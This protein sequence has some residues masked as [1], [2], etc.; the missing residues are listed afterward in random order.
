MALRPLVFLVRHGETDSNRE[1]RFAG[2]SADSLNSRGWEQAEAVARWAA[3]REEKPVRV[4]TSP[5]RRA[6]QTARVLSD[7]LGAPVRRVRELHE[8][9]VGAWKGRTAAEVA[10]RWPEAYRVWK[11]RPHEASHRVEGRED[12]EALQARML[13]ALDRIGRAEREAGGGPAIAVS[14]QAPL[15]CVWFAAH[16]RP[17]REFRQVHLGNCD[18]LP[19]R[20]AGEGE[21]EPEAASP[22]RIL[23]GAG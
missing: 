22:L 3:R 10:E 19:V 5:V 7:R 13:R 12:L 9:E 23:D 1:E 20:W 14:H 17:L 21:L 8:L 11:E 16:S 18:V 2:W 6:A 15:L 4:Y